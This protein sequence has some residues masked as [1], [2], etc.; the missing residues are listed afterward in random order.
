MKQNFNWDAAAFFER[1]TENNRHAKINGYVF[2]RV[3]SLE[4]FQGSLDKMYSSA[5]F[6]AVDDTSQGYITI[7]NSPH[8][9]R[10]KTVFLAMRH[11]EDDM[12]AREECMNN[13]RELFRQF[14]SVLLMER[15]R[16]AE[17]CI[18]LD[19][20]INFNEIDRYFFTGC[21]CAYFQIAVDTYTNL[22][23]NPDEW[24]TKV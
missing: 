8:T 19:E 3:S 17:N 15:T 2:A 20:N 4:G 7:D 13:M 6:V 22:A 5:A 12:D 23:Y 10:V 18:F 9:R 21:A 1:L 24:L 14:M 11:A 16:L